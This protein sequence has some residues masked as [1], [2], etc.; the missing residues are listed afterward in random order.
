[1]SED[2]K[3]KNTEVV[4][5]EVIQDHDHNHDHDHD[6]TLDLQVEISCV[7]RSRVPDARNGRAGLIRGRGGLAVKCFERVVSHCHPSNCL[8][9]EI[10]LQLQHCF[11]CS[12]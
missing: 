12:G 10:A 9:S 2:M 5:E 7:N 3:N 4:N 8:V 11:T 1:M 6:H